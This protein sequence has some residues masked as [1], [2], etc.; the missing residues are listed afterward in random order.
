ML[1]PSGKKKGVSE[2]WPQCFTTV[3][4]LCAHGSELLGHEYFSMAE[5]LG[6][7]TGF[8]SIFF[9]CVCLTGNVETCV[10]RQG[11]WARNRTQSM[12]ALLAKREPLLSLS[13][14]MK[15]LQGSYLTSA[16]QKAASY[17][18]PS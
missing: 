4:A 10:R 3:V 14:I 17:I 7:G 18:W 15:G 1:I 11:N 12:S 9:L 16:H 13:L 2:T 6:L 8:D 5:S